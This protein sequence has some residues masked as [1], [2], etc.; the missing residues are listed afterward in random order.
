MRFYTSLPASPQLADLADTLSR[1]GR[2][3]ELRPLTELPAQRA[4]R[5]APLRLEHAELLESLAFIN[6]SLA[7]LA[8]G[9]WQPDAQLETA[10]HADRAVLEARRR[11]LAS[12]LYPLL[13]A[14]RG[15]VVRA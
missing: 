6:W 9:T 3:V 8:N 13:Q 15:G 1:N 2:A 5:L 11:A 10:L 4:Q 12:L 14:E 7:L